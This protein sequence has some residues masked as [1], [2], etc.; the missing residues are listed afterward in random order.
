[1][2]NPG[3][4]LPAHQAL[5]LLAVANQVPLLLAHVSDSSYL[6]CCLRLSFIHAIRGVGLLP[7]Y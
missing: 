4:S 2:M 7:S 3:T 1:M 5:E 6:Q